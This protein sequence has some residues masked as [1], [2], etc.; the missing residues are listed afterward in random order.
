MGLLKGKYALGLPLLR[1][2]F[3]VQSFVTFAEV[4]LEEIK[5]VSRK[6][7]SKSSELDPLPTVVLKRCLTVLLPTIMRIIN[8]S[9]SIGVVPDALK[10][11]ILSPTLKKSDRRIEQ[12]VNDIDGWMV[13][14]GLKLNQDKTELVFSSSKFRCTLSLEFIQVVHENPNLPPEIWG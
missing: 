9:L 11:A 12:C 4:T 7:L 5:N 14:N 2:K 6:P 1:S 3:V 8:L 10:V 13:N